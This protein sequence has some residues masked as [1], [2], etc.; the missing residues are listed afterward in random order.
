MNNES[1]ERFAELIIKES[2]QI[3]ADSSRQKLTPLV[4][5]STSRVSAKPSLK[6]VMFQMLIGVIVLLAGCI[7]LFDGPMVPAMWQLTSVLWLM[8]R[9]LK[10]DNNSIQ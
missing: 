1:I 10:T 2:S 4:S 6:A 5:V 9:I 3:A 8:W 7:A